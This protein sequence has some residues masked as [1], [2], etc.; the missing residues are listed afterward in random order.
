MISP[1]LFFIFSKFWFSGSVGG[2]KGKKWPIMTKNS[3][4]HTPYLRN[5]T[6]CDCDFWYACVKWW[7]LQQIFSFLKSW[8]LGFVWGKRAKNDLKWPISVCFALYLRS[9][10]SYHQDF[11]NDVYSCFSLYFFKKMQHFFTCVWF[12]KIT[13]HIQ[14]S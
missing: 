12:F 3:V 9:G 4:C 14:Q 1:D 2:L 11:D 10:G 8:F 5:H 6:S 7:Y 13:S